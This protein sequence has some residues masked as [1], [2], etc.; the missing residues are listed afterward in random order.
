MRPHRLPCIV[1]F[2]NEQIV[3]VIEISHDDD[4]DE[5]ENNGNV[6]IDDP[7]TDNALELN[8]DANVLAGNRIV[9]EV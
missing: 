2:E 4:H 5:L 7:T 3:D 9:E 1:G 8:I 6:D